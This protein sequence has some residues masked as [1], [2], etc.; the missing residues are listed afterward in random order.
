MESQPSIQPII[1][2][3]MPIEIT[4]R[5]SRSAPPE[6]GNSFTDVATRHETLGESP[7][8]LKPSGWMLK[9]SL[10]PF[11]E[12][13]TINGKKFAQCL[14]CGKRYPEG[15]ST[16]NLSKHIRHAHPAAF[17]NKNNDKV[18]KSRTLDVFV[19]RS[20]A[21]R[22]SSIIRDEYKKNPEAFQTV[23]LVTEGFLPFSYVQLNTWNI[24]NSSRQSKFIQSRTTLVKKLELFSGYMD[25]CL[26]LNLKDTHLVNV[27]LDIWT[28]PNGESFLGIMVS[29]VPN[30]FNETTLRLATA[31]S[32]FF[33]RNNKAQN[34]HLLDFVSLGT[35]SHTGQ[36][37]Y[38]LVSSLLEKHKLL[39]KVATITMDN[40]TNNGAFYS[41][42]VHDNLKLYKPLA[43]R[44]FKRVRYIRCTSH[45]LNLQ[46]QKLFHHLYS[47]VK[48][49][50]AYTNIVKLAKIMR[51]STRIATGLKIAKV[52][53]IPLE[54]P[55]RWMLKW[56]QIERFLANRNLYE[57]WCQKTKEMGGEKLSSK[58]EKY[59]ILDARTAQLLKYFVEACEL[60]NNLTLKLQEDDYNCLSNAVPFYY[61]LDHYYTAASQA[62]EGVT[63][64]SSSSA[65]NFS[66][67][68]GSSALHPEDRE[69]VLQAMMVAQKSHLNYFAEVK[70]DPIYYLS[71][72]LDPRH[73]TEKLYRTMST[74]E[75]NERI[76]LCEAFIRNYFKEYESIGPS[77]EVNTCIE[78]SCHTD[79]NIFDFDR[80]LLGLVDTNAED[81]QVVDGNAVDTAEWINY[82]GE[83]ILASNSREAAIS[84]WFDRRLRFPRL[85]K[86]AMS[87]FYTKISTCDVERCFSLAGR[88][89]RKD[90][91]RLTRKNV[92]T[93]MVLR[94]RFLK[95]DFYQ[96]DTSSLT[97]KEF[98]EVENESELCVSDF[99]GSDCYLDS[100][101][102]DLHL[103]STSNEETCVSTDSAEDLTNSSL[104]RRKEGN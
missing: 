91:T 25:E 81:E 87:C 23:L 90:R 31:P 76:Q 97:P 20:T 30:I 1:T 85:F 28:A 102:D 12:F 74:P 60:F 92:R 7:K 104:S 15:E 9:S 17:K 18:K 2:Q 54:C 100:E 83:P 21:L 38:T 75:A 68:N 29:F 88:V 3:P 10:R 26:A 93:S 41:F 103:A 72:M 96:C 27:L 35:K 39:D 40:A 57:A 63:F 78:P 6:A 58:M 62:V 99:D 64:S 48:F 101:E 84:W 33:N 8:S 50:D 79:Q 77:E 55:T 51:Y 36:Y 65:T 89:M 46:V 11:F 43:H 70:K 4:G 42:L 37:I 32:I 86:L 16:G 47:E 80:H 67:L 61:L 52:P 98:E 45:V 59:L 44:L 53:V 95:F 82:L 94:D 69:L 13:P 19:R 24:I 22:V 56:R 34:T 14:Y 66:C 49:A 5:V 71:V 73:K